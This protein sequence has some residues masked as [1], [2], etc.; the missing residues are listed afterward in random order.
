MNRVGKKTKKS[1]SPLVEIEGLRIR[2]EEA[3][4][5]LRAIRRGDIDGLVVQGSEG[6]Q[7]YTLK[8]A[9]ESYRTL[10]EKMNEGALIVDG[11]FTI[12]YAN[13]RYAELLKIPLSEVIGAKA[14]DF[15]P[16]DLRSAFE[17]LLAEG[18]EGPRQQ[19]T[20]LRR[21]DRR[22]VPVQV[23]ASPARFEALSGLCVLITDL[24]DQKEREAARDTDQRNAQ[25]EVLRHSR[26]LEA[27]NRELEAFIYSV[28]H[29]LRAPLRHIHRFSTLVREDYAKT[30]D[31]EALDYLKR[32][33]DSAEQMDRLIEG[34]L[35]YSRLSRGE[36]ALRPIETSQ[37][38]EEVLRQL[39][40]EA[41]ESRAEITVE[42]PLL[43]VWGDVLLLTQ[44]LTNLLSNALKFVASG[45][46][47]KVRLWSELRGSNVR[48]WI[49]DRG[50]GISRANQEKKL[51]RVFERL[52][53]D[54]YPGTGIGLAI[55]KRAADRMGGSVGVESEIGK[56]S[57]FWIELRKPADPS[58]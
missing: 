3:E 49:E 29:D 6:S 39:Y 50:I 17:T 21:S 24:S 38:V 9:D 16:T 44:A 51:F 32:V 31:A 33:S 26:E 2:L 12:L 30:L 46:V 23:S 53:G 47:P 40:E 13:R 19:E 28:S 48:L 37:V 27:S 7:V 8:G 42:T 18:K 1:L 11:Q 54:H 5:T 22:L 20:F 10:I 56:G 36:I 25:R 41:K 34:L 4:E 58:P 55:V 43:P 52:E 57:S 45:S 14:G 35:E 15:V